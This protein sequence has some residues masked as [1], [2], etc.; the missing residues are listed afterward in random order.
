[1]AATIAYRRNT[2]PC[3]GVNLFLSAQ[4]GALLASLVVIQEINARET[5]MWPPYSPSLFLIFSFSLAL[6]LRLSSSP[7]TPWLILVLYYFPQ[8]SI[9]RPPGFI[10]SFDLATCRRRETPDHALW[11]S[12]IDPPWGVGRVPDCD[13]YLTLLRRRWSLISTAGGL[14]VEGYLW[15]LGPST[16]QEVIGLLLWEVWRLV[17]E[18][19]SESCTRRG[20]QFN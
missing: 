12:C 7:S 17:E 4:P 10:M 18:Q 1:M 15:C 20:V 19:A 6:S 8:A 9:N 14:S 16:P 2:G 5:M 11:W 3:L 13:L